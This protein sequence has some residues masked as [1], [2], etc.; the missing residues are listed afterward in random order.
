[1]F[2]EDWPSFVRWTASQYRLGRTGADCA[3]D[4]AKQDIRWR[5]KIK[6]NAID[7]Q[8]LHGLFLDPP[9]IC[10]PL[11]DGWTL[12]ASHL[13]LPIDAAETADALRGLHVGAHVEF[14]GKICSSDGIFPGIEFSRDEEQ[15]KVYL[16]VA[17]TLRR[18]VRA[19]IRIAS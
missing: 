19:N 15:R 5:G 17:V 14:E 2:A 9:E 12:T 3:T 18:I 13:F 6:R 11:A 16:Q 7:D 1:M 8:Y 4:A 10:V